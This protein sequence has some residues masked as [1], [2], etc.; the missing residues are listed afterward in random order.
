[1]TAYS[2]HPGLLPSDGALNMRAAAE[3]LQYSLAQ[4]D[5]ATLL[6]QQNTTHD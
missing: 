2:S 5:T 4:W 1:M 3:K 6:A